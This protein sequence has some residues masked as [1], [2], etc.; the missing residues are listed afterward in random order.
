MKR[1]PRWK[2][3]HD[4]RE[5]AVDWC[6]KGNDVESWYCLLLAEALVWRPPNTKKQEKQ[7]KLWQNRGLLERTRANIM[8]C[9]PLT[10]GAARDNLAAARSTVEFMIDHNKYQMRSL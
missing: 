10:T 2:L 1:E 9:M 4:Y 5:Q 6:R 8:S 3:W 7:Q